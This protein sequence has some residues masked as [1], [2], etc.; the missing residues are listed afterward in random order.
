MKKKG[1]K[2]RSA[3]RP[4]SYS[5]LLINLSEADRIIPDVR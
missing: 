4:W 2:K 3:A 1:K 5:S